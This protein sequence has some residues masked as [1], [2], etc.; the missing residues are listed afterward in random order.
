MP[1]TLAYFKY[2]LAVFS[3]QKPIYT[4]TTIQYL[5]ESVFN[6]LKNTKK[7]HF[8]QNRYCIP[9]EF[10]IQLVNETEKTKTVCDLNTNLYQIQEHTFCTYS[11]QIQDRIAWLECQ[12]YFTFYEPMMLRFRIDWFWN[13][14]D[15]KKAAFQAFWNVEMNEMNKLT[16]IESNTMFSLYIRKDNELRALTPTII[17]RTLAELLHQKWKLEAYVNF[18][19]LQ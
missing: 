17:S 4:Y 13:M 1:V 6:E 11:I 10:I 14:Q 2:E 16:F 19:F 12:T 18:W 3:T 8:Y 7:E 5:L 9:S 15:I